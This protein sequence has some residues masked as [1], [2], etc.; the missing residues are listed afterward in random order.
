MGTAT[1]VEQY[2]ETNIDVNVKPELNTLLK[3][4]CI[5][6]SDASQNI[7]E[8]NIVGGQGITIEQINSAKN[9]CALKTV[10]DFQDKLQ[11][12]QEVLEKA[13]NKVYTQG[14][15]GVTVSKSKLESLTNVSTTIEPK[16]KFEVM[17]ECL[18]NSLSRQNIGKV[19]IKDSADI[20]ISQTNDTLNDCLQDSMLKLEKEYDVDLN[21][22]KDQ[23]IIADTLGWDP[24]A[25]ILGAL[26]GPWVMVA[27]AC[28]VCMC[29][30]CVGLLL[31][32][33]LSGK[34]DTRIMSEAVETVT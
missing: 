7:D 28:S 5:Q 33:M 16:V 17:K 12:S 15:L 2:L 3:E 20:L 10:M 8:I 19:N 14:G 30:L 32:F 24:I 29:L 34:A 26:T 9:I 22:E 11:L 4:S 27:G 31:W 6:G 1:D 21:L 13:L 23:G 25:S 18:Q